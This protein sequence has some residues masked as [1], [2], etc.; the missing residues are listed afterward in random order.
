LSSGLGV[1]SGLAADGAR[2]F[3]SE[4]GFFFF[5]PDGL[6]GVKGGGPQGVTC[7]GRVW[8]RTAP[9]VVT[10]M[11]AASPAAKQAA[12]ASRFSPP[13]SS[14]LTVIPGPRYWV[15]R[16]DDPPPPLDWVLTTLL[17]RAA[18]CWRMAK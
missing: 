3:S 17:C 10:H 14:R 5:W 2:D 12:G 7:L 6:H 18:N 1:E 15:M 16:T 8:A 4:R 11:A 13:A 9:S